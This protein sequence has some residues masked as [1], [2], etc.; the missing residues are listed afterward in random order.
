M[1]LI[2]GF[3]DRVILVAGIVVGGCLPSF[4]SQYRQRIG[5]QLDQVLKDL[6][7][8]QQIANKYHNGSLRELVQHHLES[9][10]ASFNEEGAAVQV[11]LNSA[12]QM[13]LA[14]QALSTDLFHQVIYLVTGGLDPIIAK[15][16]WEIFSPA[17]VLTTESVV[18][19]IVV[20]LLV[21]ITFL[22]IWKILAA[23]VD[24]IS[25]RYFSST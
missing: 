17:F 21:W 5:G 16:A 2:R 22:F 3:L 11:M 24:V 20:G 10:D 12:E 8:F 25:G 19:S 1:S 7:A 18:F 14:M 23:F 9:K 4:I 13:K 15:A 6:D